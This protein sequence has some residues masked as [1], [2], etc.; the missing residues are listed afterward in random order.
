MLGGGIAGAADRERQLECTS[1]GRDALREDPAVLLPGDEQRPRAGNRDGGIGNRAGERRLEGEVVR[2]PQASGIEALHEHAR[3]A[4]GG[5]ATAEARPGHD[6]AGAA[7]RH[8]RAARRVAAE[9]ELRHQD[10]IAEHVAPGV[11]VAGEDRLLAAV[12]TT[13]DD[14][15]VTRRAESDVGLVVAEI[16]HHA[17]AEQRSEQLTCRVVALR[18]DGIAPRRLDAGAPGERDRRVRS[19][20]ERG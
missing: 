7:G 6:V 8:P 9:V 13:P 12:V 17:R 20:G 5:A 2:E 18:E 11:V 1:V 14:H 19:D 3:R 4:G 10:G 15:E 16:V